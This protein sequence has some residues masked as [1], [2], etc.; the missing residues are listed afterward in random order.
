MDSP[1]SL[2]RGQTFLILAKDFGIMTSIAWDMT[3]PIYYLQSQMEIPLLK[4][5]VRRRL[6]QNQLHSQH[7]NHQSQ[8]LF[9]S[10]LTKPILLSLPTSQTLATL[11]NTEPN[12]PR[13]SGEL[14]SRTAL[15][16]PSIMH[17]GTTIKMASTRVSHLASFFSPPRTNIPQAPV[18]HHLPSQSKVHQSLLAQTTLSEW[19]E[20]RLAAL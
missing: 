17:T 6:I 15:R 7:R 11:S 16:E 14:P 19:S 2:M 20:M 12:L 8:N 18:G 1:I 10:L 13:S 9:Q 3:F 4:L 5:V